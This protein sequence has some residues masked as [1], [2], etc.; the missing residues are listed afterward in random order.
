MGN[1]TFSL[2]GYFPDFYQSE[3]LLVFPI[4][5]KVCS[6]VKGML[7]KDSFWGFLLGHCLLFIQEGLSFEEGCV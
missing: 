2:Y 7:L 6:D 5:F 3:N 1:C 4:L